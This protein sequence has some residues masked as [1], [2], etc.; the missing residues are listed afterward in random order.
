MKQLLD[1]LGNVLFSDGNHT[2]YYI[3]WSLLASLCKKWS[4]NRDPD[5]KRVKEMVQF[6]RGGGHL[7]KML[8]LA[9]VED[10]GLVCYDGNHRR[11][12][13]QR[14][15]GVY[16]LID[17][18][19]NCTQLDVL[20]AFTNLNKSVQ[21]PLIY[22]ED[23]HEETK[24]EI[25]QLV[26]KFEQRYPE[27]VKSSANCRSPHFNRDVFIDNLFDIYK[28]FEG[29]ITVDELGV[30]LEA[31]NE[32][33][34]RGFLRPH[35]IYTKPGQLHA[36]KKCERFHFWLFLERTI[37]FEHIEFVRAKGK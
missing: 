6:C 3:K 22:L 13:F 7:P 34:A 24:G 31:L 25:L 21:V 28:A 27:F 14:L 37:P 19:F 20:D 10:E 4:R 9:E 18:M 17:V 23:V 15:E 35:S 26:R 32:E 29:A 1:R 36:I 11:E 12:V 30:L 5:S 8:F 16:C 33:Y 2:V